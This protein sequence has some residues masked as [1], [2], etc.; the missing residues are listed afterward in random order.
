MLNRLTT[1]SPVLCFARSFH[2]R[3]RPS[4]NALAQMPVFPIT[5]TSSMTHSGSKSKRA[6][7]TVPGDSSTPPLSLFAFL[8]TDLQLEYLLPSELGVSIDIVT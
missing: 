6:C 5:R 2:I 1:F 8:V 4:I 3:N 7:R